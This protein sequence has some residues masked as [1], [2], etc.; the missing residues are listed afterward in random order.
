MSDTYTTASG[1]KIRV[2]GDNVLVL[3]DEPPDRSKSGLVIYPDGAMTHVFNTGVV[4]AVGYVWHKT[5]KGRVKVPVPGLETGLRVAFIRF[6]AE[7]NTNKQVRV[8]AN[9]DLLRIKA[10]DVVLVIP[11]GEEDK[12]R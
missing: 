3:A 7:Q 9:E 1:V 10:S 6:L 12:F 8:L 5:S 11:P 4:V 2:I